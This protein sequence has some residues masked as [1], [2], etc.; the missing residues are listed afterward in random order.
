[1]RLEVHEVGH[2][3]H[4]VRLGNGLAVTNGQ[5]AVLVGDAHVIARDEEMARDRV[6]RRHH[7][8]VERRPAVS[9]LVSRASAATSSI[10]CQRCAANSSA[11]EAAGRAIDRSSSNAR[12]RAPAG[13]GSMGQGSLAMRCLLAATLSDEDAAR[14]HVDG[15]GVSIPNSARGLVSLTSRNASD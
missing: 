6:E 14:I 2:Q 3:R 11:A 15:M 1:M 5:W 13:M 12:R 4:D 8:C 9:I 10:S 7:A